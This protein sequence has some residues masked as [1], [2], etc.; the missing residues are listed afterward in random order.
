MTPADNYV[1]PA[2]PC[3][4]SY[5]ELEAWDNGANVQTC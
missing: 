2:I 4:T 3:R 5:A 1:T